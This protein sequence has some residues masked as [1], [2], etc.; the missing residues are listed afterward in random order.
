MVRLDCATVVNA[1]IINA[2][3]LNGIF[4]ICC[5]LMAVWVFRAQS[6]DEIT[7][8]AFLKFP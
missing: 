6:Y 4:F 1:V 5:N 7:V 2:Q 3:R 8:A